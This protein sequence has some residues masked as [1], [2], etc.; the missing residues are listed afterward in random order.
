MSIPDHIP[1]Y[2]LNHVQR[3]NIFLSVKEVIN[4]AIKH[5]QAT[6]ITIDFQIQTETCIITIQDNGVGIPD[7]IPRQGNGLQNIR[8]RMEIIRSRMEMKNRNGTRIRFYINLDFKN[9]PIG[10]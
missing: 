5:A 2:K 7:G 3:K 10:L 4:N 8:K 1:K 9:P 6:A